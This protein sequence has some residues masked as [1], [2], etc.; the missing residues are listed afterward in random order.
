MT[1]NNAISLWMRVKATA[2][3]FRGCG[4]GGVVK[5]T[6]FELRMFGGVF[7]VAFSRLR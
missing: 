6:G 3:E 7:G 2:D 4:I 5:L 1:L